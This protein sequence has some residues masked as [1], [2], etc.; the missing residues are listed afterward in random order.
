MRPV[1]TDL[2]VVHGHYFDPVPT[3][4]HSIEVRCKDTNKFSK[5]THHEQNYFFPQAKQP[6]QAPRGRFPRWHL[7]P[8]RMAGRLC[9]NCRGIMPRT[10]RQAQG[11]AVGLD[12]LGAHHCRG[13]SGFCRLPAG[14]SA[15][16]QKANEGLR[17]PSAQPLVLHFHL[18]SLIP[19]T[20]KPRT[21]RSL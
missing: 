18:T 15:G 14:I 16:R 1:I 6:L 7:R 4:Q 3:L 10:Q 9:R 2:G 5:T 17:L 13:L 21:G 8:R 19:N 11:R 20:Y 12:R